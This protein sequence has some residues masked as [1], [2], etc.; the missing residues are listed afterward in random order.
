MK[1]SGNLL[2]ML[3]TILLLASCSKVVQRKNIVFLVP[4][5]FRSQKWES[6]VNSARNEFS[7]TSK[8]NLL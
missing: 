4:S 2:L 7:D 8:Y 1:K 5:E 6:F 3:M